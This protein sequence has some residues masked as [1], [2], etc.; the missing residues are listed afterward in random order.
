MTI[1]PIFLHPVI[2]A[3]TVSAIWGLNVVFMKIAMDDLPPLLFNTLRF[4]VLILVLLP[5]VRINFQQ[6]RQLLPLALVMGMGHFYLLA[7]GLTYV[8]SFVA[9][10][11][12]LLGGPFSAFLGYLILNERLTRWQVLAITI[13]TLGATVPSLLSGNISL[14]MGMLL[15]TLST[16]L[17]AVGNIQVRRLPSIS[18]M[19]IQFCI[20]IITAPIS[21][22]FYW[23][24]HDITATMDY[25]TLPALASLAYVVIFSSIIG[26]ALWYRLI[27][28]HG[29]QQITPF[30]LIQPVFT[31]IFGYLILSESLNLWQWLGSGVT[32][33]AIYSYNKLQRK[34]D[35]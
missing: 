5:F 10:F 9:S 28:T 22:V 25:I 29:I 21:F 35:A 14:Q 34:P 6:L 3:L 30:A 4:S 33:M 18:T 23:Y 11:C 26:Y 12:L 2:G 20:A 17:W 19:S 8:P 13:A 32:L 27:H 7:I 31:L 24:T 16:F 1:P 15:I